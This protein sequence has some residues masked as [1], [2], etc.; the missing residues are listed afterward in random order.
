MLRRTLAALAAGTLVACASS[1]GPVGPGPG[2]DG[3]PVA[4]STTA[5]G[6]RRGPGVTG[7]HVWFLDP[8]SDPG[9]AGDRVQGWRISGGRALVAAEVER[10]AAILNDPE[11]YDPTWE[12]K[13][14][15]PGFAV[16]RMFEGERRDALVCL[17][18]R[19]VQ[20]YSDGELAEDMGLSDAGVEALSAL[21]QALSAP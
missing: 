21:H 10:A 3:A 14:F 17:H 16:V 5:A 15:S 1:G 2:G 12:S 6:A 8:A 11:T 20:F 9:A 4:S 18:C 13:C 7:P 19:V